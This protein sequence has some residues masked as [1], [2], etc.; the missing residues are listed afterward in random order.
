MPEFSTP[1]SSPAIGRKLLKEELIRAIRYSIAAENEAIKLYMQSSEAS[2]DPL[3][4]AVLKDIA[5]EER[6]HA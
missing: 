4:T 3:S 1:F 6:D 2:D 5:D